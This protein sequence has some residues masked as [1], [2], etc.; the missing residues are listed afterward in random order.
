MVGQL[1]SH[2]FHPCI[3]W[4]GRATGKMDAAGLEFH[5]KQQIESHPP[6]VDAE[7]ETTERLDGLLRSYRRA[8]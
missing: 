1:A 6:V 8:A 2:L 3:M 7:L 4:I 5:D